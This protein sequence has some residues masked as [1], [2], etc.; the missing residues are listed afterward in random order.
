MGIIEDLKQAVARLEN[1]LVKLRDAEQDLSNWESHDL[2]R[3]DGSGA[4]DARHQE[5]GR[6]SRDDVSEAKRQVEAQKALVASLLNG[7]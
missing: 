2:T 4:Q 1:D 5:I 6:S 7:I 3:E